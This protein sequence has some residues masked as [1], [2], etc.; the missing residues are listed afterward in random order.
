MKTTPPLGDQELDTLRFIAERAPIS[1]GEVAKDYGMPRGLARTTILTVMERLR[2]KGYL[3][4]KQMKGV[5]R[6]SPKLDHAHVLSNLV[7][8][9]VQRSLGG[10]L[11]PFVTYMA[12]SG[13]LNESEIEHLK[14]M[15]E[16]LEARTGEAS[17]L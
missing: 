3:S 17:E 16:A 1:V 11:S 15:V 5:Y 13:G 7:G 4:R 8:D 10:S 9:F 6:Y 14:R 12:D 2:S